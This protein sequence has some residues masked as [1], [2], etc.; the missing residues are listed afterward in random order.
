MKTIDIPEDFMA[1]RPMNLPPVER[2]IFADGD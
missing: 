2:D 1:D